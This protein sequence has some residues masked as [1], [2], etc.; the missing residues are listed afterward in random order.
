MGSPALLV[1]EEDAGKGDNR[2]RRLTR[3]RKSRTDKDW[4]GGVRES[5][6]A[7]YFLERS[8]MRKIISGTLFMALAGT[9]AIATPRQER[10]DHRDRGEKHD[11]DKHPG[12]YKHG[13]DRG[14]RH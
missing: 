8:P 10:D 12:D 6:P 14:D 13:D 9:L 5:R 1:V 11:K 3:L 4:T 7:P 2:K